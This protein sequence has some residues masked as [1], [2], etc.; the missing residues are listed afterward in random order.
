[1][2]DPDLDIFLDYRFAEIESEL[3]AVEQ[4]RLALEAQL[5]ALLES[6]RSRLREELRQQYGPDE[7]E[8]RYQEEA[9][10]DEFIDYELPRLIRY[11]ILVSLWAV[12]ESATFNIAKELQKKRGQSLGLNDIRGG[13]LD[14]AKKY[15]E[16]VLT[17]PLTSDQ[18]ELKWVHML[19]VIRNAI[20]H[21]NGRREAVK[22]DTWRSIESWNQSGIDT[23]LQYLAFSGEFIARMVEVVTKSLSRLIERAKN[24]I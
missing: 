13:V 7:G 15:F 10:V 8:L 16:H 5:P 4:H 21:G 23:D 22:P 6:E 24:E 11:P 1:M 9:W 19:A 12:Y 20:A 14:K 3:Y 17:F 2:S 18:N